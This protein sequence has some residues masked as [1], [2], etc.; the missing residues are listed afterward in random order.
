MARGTREETLKEILGDLAGD[1]NFYKHH[2]TFIY[3]INDGKL[4]INEFIISVEDEYMVNLGPDY[5][6]PE[7][8]PILYKV[9]TR[10]VQR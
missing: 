8:Q 6:H 5:K 7:V 9:F 2:T 1:G 10:Q 4:T 3:T